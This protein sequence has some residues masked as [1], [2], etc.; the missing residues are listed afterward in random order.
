M[1]VSK[2]VEQ[3]TNGFNSLFL[4][5]S[6]LSK[7]DVS[8]KEFK[9]EPL[10]KHLS[11]LRVINEN[12]FPL[13]IFPDSVRQLI[14]ATNK[15]LKFPID[16]LASSAVFA[17]SLAVGNSYKAQVLPNYRQSAVMYMAIVASRGDNKSHPLNFMLAP[18]QKRDSL[19]YADFERK[20]AE[21]ESYQGMSA[22]E[23]IENGV[24]EIEKPTWKQFLASDITPEALCEVHYYNKRGVGIKM[25][26]LKGWFS[27]FNRYNNGSEEEFWLSNWSGEEIRRNRRSSSPLFIEHPFI[28]V[29]GTTQTEVLKGITSGRIENGFFDRILFVIPENLR[30]EPL[31]DVELDESY[32]ETWSDILNRLMDIPYFNSPT[33]LKFS[34]EAKSEWLRWQGELSVKSNTELH[35]K[36]LLAKVEQNCVRF[37]L[38][39]EMMTFACGGELPN[40]ISLDSVKKA[41]KLSAY[42][43]NM[44]IKAQNII[45]NDNPLVQLSL[46]KQQLYENLKPEFTTGEG[47]VLA[48][49]FGLAERTFKTFLN[50]KKLFKSLKHGTYQKLL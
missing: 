43:F 48:N 10:K 14:E 9:P 36:P 11:E 45:E 15:T 40:S 4:S 24:S 16:I 20:Q 35:Y 2:D 6:D 5:P 23:R 28:S 26:E 3:V 31:A 50:A 47:V 8:L 37:S 41:I 33:I 42:F 19:S 46:N 7:S 21:Y 30:K 1:I 13:D 38:I 39:M 27:N 29:V 12:T 44:S 34:S 18:I 49:N 17:V 32:K 22:K 25:D